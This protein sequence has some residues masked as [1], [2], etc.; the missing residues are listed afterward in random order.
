MLCRILRL[1]R[2]DRFLEA[3][4]NLP[5]ASGET[6]RVPGN[7]PAHHPPCD[8][9]SHISG[10]AN[11][12]WHG[13]PTLPDPGHP[14]VLLPPQNGSLRGAG[15]SPSFRYPNHYRSVS[16][17]AR[18]YPGGDCHIRLLGAVLSLWSPTLLRFEVVMVVTPPR[19]WKT[20][21]HRIPADRKKHCN[22][23]QWGASYST[24]NAEF[25]LFLS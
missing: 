14:T 23:N 18:G 3:E 21:T 8:L 20:P 16:R 24:K 1:H 17:Y 15:F 22:S 13:D 4:G 2:K 25:L 11:K 5:H 19:M 9:T 6:K 10:A 12:S 7:M